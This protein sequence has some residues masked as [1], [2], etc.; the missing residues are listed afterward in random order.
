MRV[1]E[2]NSIRIFRILF[3][4]Y[5]IFLNLLFMLNEVLISI[6]C[7]SS[8]TAR[9]S[10]INYLNTPLKLVVKTNYV[11]IIQFFSIFMVSLVI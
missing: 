5:T 1:C 6:F 4:S 11:S 9:L 2:L 10:R 8:R 3:S 7:V